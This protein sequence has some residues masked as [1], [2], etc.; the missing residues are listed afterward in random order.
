MLFILFT[1]FYTVA[2]QQ[3][4]YYKTTTTFWYEDKISKSYHFEKRELYD[5]DYIFVGTSRTLYHISSD[6]FAQ[7]SIQIYN[8]GIP[9]FTLYEHALYVKQA[10][11]HRPKSIVTSLSITDLFKAP[12]VSDDLTLTDIRS[13]FKTQS[14][15][16]KSQSLLYYM[17]NIT[18]S[19]R[20]RDANYLKRDIAD[21]FERAYIYKG[22]VKTKDYSDFSSDCNIFEMKS[23]SRKRQVARCTNGDSIIYGEGSMPTEEKKLYFAKELTIPNTDAINYINGLIDDIKQH[24]IVPIIIFEPIYHNNYSYDLKS[25]GEK[26]HTTNTIDLTNYKIKNTSWADEQHLN[27][28]GRLEYSRHLLDILQHN[29]VVVRGH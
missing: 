23:I 27:N 1:I 8:F 5:L 18:E 6:I 14:Y 11:A 13:I 20:E 2:L 19:L 22:R 12:F 16:A 26:L 7:R 24:D 10:I 17:K 4:I 9:F 15:K 3:Y 29:R 28:S 21:Y 25:I